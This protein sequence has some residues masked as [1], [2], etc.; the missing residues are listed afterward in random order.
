M[1]ANE[2]TP[3][4]GRFYGAVVRVADMARCR[5]FYSEV[6]GLGKPVVNSNF[7]VEFELVPGGMVLALQQSSGTSRSQAVANVAWCLA[8]PDLA[9]FRERLTELGC[10]PTNS[11][12]LPSGVS[13]STYLDPEY[14]PFIVLERRA[15]R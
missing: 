2:Q 6:V 7:W 4:G 14:N 15:P 11:T 9:A 5:S 3:R 12:V 10:G 8:V 13:I 1:K